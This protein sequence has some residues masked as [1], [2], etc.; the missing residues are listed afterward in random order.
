[1]FLFYAMDFVILYS[2]LMLKLSQMK[3]SG[4]L[5]CPFDMFPSAFESLLAFQCNKKFRIHF[6]HV[7]LSQSTAGNSD[8]HLDLEAIM[9]TSSCKSPTGLAVIPEPEPAAKAEEES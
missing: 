2:I 8:V 4:W 6:Q 5:L 1:M 7:Y 9:P 3:P